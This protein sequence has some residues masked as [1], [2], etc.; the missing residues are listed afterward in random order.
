M[1]ETSAPCSILSKP[2]ETGPSVSIRSLT[3]R[4]STPDATLGTLPPDLGVPV[5]QKAPVAVVHDAD[6]NEVALSALI[7]KGPVLLVFYRGGWCPFCNFQIRELTAAYPEL[8]KRGV[9]P[10]AISG[11]TPLSTSRCGFGVTSGRRHDA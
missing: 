11:L 4:L 9:T 5:G 8:Q 10:V 7:A 1:V 3:R 2:A 6:G